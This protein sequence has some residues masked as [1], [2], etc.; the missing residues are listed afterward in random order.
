MLLYT[1]LH[2]R[3]HHCHDF[4]PIYEEVA[5]I[6]KPHGIQLAKVNIVTA[7]EVQSRSVG[8]ANFSQCS[9]ANC[10][11]LALPLPLSASLCAYMYPGITHIYVNHRIIKRG[12]GAYT[13]MGIYS[14]DH[15]SHPIPFRFQVKDVP[16]L[17]MFWKG[18][19]F[20]YRGP[21]DQ[22]GAQGKYSRARG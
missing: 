9:S 3:C 17:T 20:P 18:L 13:K 11:Q 14:R 1:L 12:V 15:P 8:E 10:R 7:R 5:G 16:G 2:C 21:G 19:A 22:A 6:L 4:A